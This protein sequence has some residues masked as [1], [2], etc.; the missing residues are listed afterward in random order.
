MVENKT[1]ITQKAAKR[2]AM[3]FLL[4]YLNFYEEMCL[5]NGIFISNLYI[6]YI[7][8]DEKIPNTMMPPPW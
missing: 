6:I 3:A 8:N 7:F 2:N 5:F 1:K 4:I